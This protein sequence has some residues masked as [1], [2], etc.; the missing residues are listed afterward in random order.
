MSP[1]NSNNPP[2]VVR[3]KKNQKKNFNQNGNFFELNSVSHC[4]YLPV[5]SHACNLNLPN[6]SNYSVTNGMN[7]QQ[8]MSLSNHS[9]SCGNFLPNMSTPKT[10]HG[11]EF[12]ED[13]EYS[14]LP[15]AH[16]QPDEVAMK[17]R[18]SDPGL[19]NDSDSSTNS[20]EDS[21]I[22]KLKSQMNSLKDSNRRL[23]REVMEL[24]VEMNLLKQQNSFKPYDRDYEPGVLADIIREV[25]DAARVR[26]DAFLARVKHMLEEQQQQLGLNHM[27][28]LSE[29]HKN[30]ER[31][32][33]L[34]E[35]LMNINLSGHRQEESVSSN[36]NSSNTARQV[37]ELEREALELRR[38]LQDTRAKKEASDQK[39]LQLDK[40]LSNL[41]RSSDMNNSDISDEAKTASI[42]SL[43]TSIITNAS[44]VSH[45]NSRI[46]LT[47]PVTDL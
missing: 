15:A 39:V 11:S 5:P 16:M 33:K 2:S 38:E 43:S 7:I 31:I 10:L 19:P 30:N 3:R 9:L 25:R 32:S 37:I 40:K 23:S 8:L 20:V 42:E 1:E 34:E 27:H 17:R 12:N 44:S 41:M 18:F 46:T 4:N 35:Q 28:F 21:V 6:V 45:S 14:S 24:K 36:G 26:E 29:K 47:G 22:H 13:I